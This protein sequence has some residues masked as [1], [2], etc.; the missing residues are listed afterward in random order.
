MKIIITEEQ[1]N[2]IISEHGYGSKPLPQEE[3]D[4]RLLKA[5]KVAVKFPNPRQFS[6]KY[7]NLWNF[8]R[9]KGL[10]DDV[11]PNRKLYKNDG[12]WTPETISQEASKYNTKT[13][14]LRSNQVAYKKAVELGILNDLIPIDGRYGS[15]GNKKK[16]T[17]EKSIQVAKEFEGTKTEFWKKHPAAT[18]ELRRNNLLKSIFPDDKRKGDDDILINQAKEYENRS[19]LRRDNP[20]LYSKLVIRGMLYDVFPKVEM[21]ADEIITKA[22]E[23]E[24]PTELSKGNQNLYLKLKKIPNGYELAFGKEYKYKKLFDIAKQYQN[25]YELLKGNAYVYNNLEKLGLLNK[26]YGIEPIEKLSL[27]NTFNK[28]NPEPKRKDKTNSKIKS[29]EDKT[30]KEKMELIRQLRSKN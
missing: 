29:Y 1:L 10:L 9:S 11:F 7:P 20:S 2:N 16:W 25:K 24:T 8:L 23:Y 27:T 4:K 5:K 22:K 3:V 17:L 6:L 19:V 18:L 13:E 28:I 30:T 26:A 15:S 21:T 14:F 12:Y